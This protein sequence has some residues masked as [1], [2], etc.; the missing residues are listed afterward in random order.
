MAVAIWQL[1][2]AAPAER[3]AMVVG[4]T[5]AVCPW[6]ILMFAMPPLA[7]LL[8]ALRGL[9]PTRLALTGTT[10]GI[11][12]GGAGAGIY[13]L[14]CGEATVPFLTVWYTLGIAM[15]AAIGLAGGAW[16]LRW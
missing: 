7:G 9:A 14:H 1:S 2:E 12:A 11:A 5:A 16:F 4:Q 13:A 3:M 10:V 6:G 15:T 8:W